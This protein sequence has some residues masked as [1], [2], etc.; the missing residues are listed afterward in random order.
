M[1]RE[2]TCETLERL[3]GKLYET[4]QVFGEHIA[5]DGVVYVHKAL[6]PAPLSVTR[7][8]DGPVPT[9]RQPKHAAFVLTYYALVRAAPKGATH[10]PRHW[11]RE[12]AKAKVG[13]ATY[14]GCPI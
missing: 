2:I 4:A 1:R 6:L 8:K 13:G 3:S 10:S 11:R 12:R 9:Q 14:E 5:G 7:T